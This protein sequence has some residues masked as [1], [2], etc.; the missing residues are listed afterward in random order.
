MHANTHYSTS[1]GCGNRTGALRD[2][3]MKVVTSSVMQDL[4][5]RAIHDMGVPGVVLMENAGRAVFE[6]LCE[7]FGPLR[8][9][10]IAVFCG[11][12]NNGGDGFVVA[13]YLKLAGADVRVH[14]AGEMD[15]VRG[16]AASHL[17]VLRSLGV[18]V[19]QELP[20]AEIAVD[21][22]LGTGAHGAPREGIAE[23]IGH[24]NRTAR[25]V[26]AVD[27]P[28]GVDAD[29][30]AVPGAA[31]LAD[32]TVTFGY[33][34][35]GLL[36]APGT[37]L[38]GEIIVRDIGF[39]WSVL[40]ASSPYRW[41]DAEEVRAC[42][43]KRPRDAHKGTFGH[44]LVVGGSVG[45]SGAPTLAARAAL[46]CGAGLATVAAPESAQRLV[47]PR[48]DEVITKP[49]PECAGALCAESLDQVL[50]AATLADAVCIGPGGTRLP[51]AQTLFRRLMVEIGKPMVADADALNALAEKP[52]D[53]TNRNAPIVLTPHPGECGRLLGI[54]AAQVQEDRLGAVTQTAKRYRA[55]VVLKGARTLIADGS[56]SEV[57]VPVA[58]NTTGN[59]GMA[60]GGSGDVLTGMIGALL[61]RGIGAFEA[62]C[63]GVYL[64]G[65]A[66][67]L[68]AASLGEH[69]MVAG[70]IIRFT[71]A[72]I[73]TLEETE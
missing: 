4:D 23:A 37:W 6:V 19:T 34:K 72:A 22:L 48:A 58:V 62:A 63:A 8:A 26:I 54:S 28:S 29:T 69:S 56:S 20:S 61:A 39:D 44:V 57:E 25:H 12:G 15:R 67:D 16:D 10:H 27:V 5:R 32:I 30:G 50:D 14:L 31:V 60:T 46:S 38:A 33:P 24:L 73:K 7:R 2:V 13:R 3:M 11:T 59:P 68:A 70:D 55:V 64:H 41:V 47:A 65:L 52:V 17:A 43:P 53:L 66:G 9:R 1:E 49:V 71:S 18:S 40:P 51:G 42:F 21:A 45:M 35:L 36:L